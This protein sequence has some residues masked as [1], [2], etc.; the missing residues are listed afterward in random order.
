M[1]RGELR[2]SNFDA[3]TA[4]VLNGL[5]QRVSRRSMIARVGKF[6]FGL[7]GVSLVPLLPLDRIVVTE[8]NAQSG[9][10]SGCKKWELCGIWGRLCNKCN[11]RCETGPGA[12]EC[13]SCTIKGQFWASCCN[14]RD[15]NGNPTTSWLTV[16]YIDCCG[17]RGDQSSA[18]CATGQFCQGNTVDPPTPQRNW[19]MG[20]GG[21]DYKCTRYQVLT[22]CTP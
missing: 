5:S 19:C 21:D 8:A 1:S 3:A 15:A 22:S 20:A 17:Q 18:S 9:W 7:L 11:C 6:A 4:R 12:D 10:G 16:K 13:P 2:E 14:V